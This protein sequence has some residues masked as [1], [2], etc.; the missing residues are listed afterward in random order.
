MTDLES[1]FTEINIGLQLS[2]YMCFEIEET[3]L[4]DFE[5]DKVH[6]KFLNEFKCLVEEIILI[7]ECCTLKRVLLDLLWQQRS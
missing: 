2:K 1:K 5:T 4:A 3:H 6:H 7:V